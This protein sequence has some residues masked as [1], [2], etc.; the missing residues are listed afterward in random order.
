MVTI[1]ESDA[2]WAGEFDAI[3]A[4][5]REATSESVVRIDH[6]GSTS[7]RQLPAKDVIDVQITVEDGAAL[8]PVVERLATR[9]WRRVAD[10]VDDHQ[11]PGLS[12]SPLSGGSSSCVNPME[13]GARMCTSAYRAERISDMRC[14]S[15]TSSAHPDSAASYATVKR[16][17]AMLAPDTDS[18]A[19]AKDPA[20]DLI[21]RA[22]E[23]WA[24]E[25]GW[26]SVVPPPPP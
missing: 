5:L 23:A 20:C 25:V 16:G 8:E 22:A 1:V 4:R 12:P 2:R 10:I 3:A 18:Y 17:L 14:S 26:D 13:S 6:I 11:V 21:Y 19:D 15:V 9:G 7:V 24:K